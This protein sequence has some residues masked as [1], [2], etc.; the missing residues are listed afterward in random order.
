MLRNNDNKI[1]SIIGPEVEVDGDVRVVGS[2]LIYGK[3]SRIPVS[4]FVNIP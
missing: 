4:F 3:F 2:I 1:N